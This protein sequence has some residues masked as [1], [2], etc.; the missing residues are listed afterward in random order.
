MPEPNEDGSEEGGRCATVLCARGQ[1]SDVDEFD[2]QCCWYETYGT[3]N[4]YW[5]PIRQSRGCLFIG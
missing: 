1:V 4:G 3:L 5:S 2:I